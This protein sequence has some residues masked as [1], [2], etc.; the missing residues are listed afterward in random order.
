MPAL[1]V[2]IVDLAFTT[3]VITAGVQLGRAWSRWRGDGST[4]DSGGWRWRHT[5]RPPGPDR[6]SPRNAVPRR[7]PTSSRRPRTPAQ[8]G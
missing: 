3:L 4:D 1:A 7:D 5:P 6:H 8:R 2:F